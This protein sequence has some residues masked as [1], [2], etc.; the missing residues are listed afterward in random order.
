MLFAVL[1]A[2]YKPHTDWNAKSP[3]FHQP[4]FDTRIFIRR[5][6][7]SF[8]IDFVT[9]QWCD[10][11]MSHS[12]NHFHF[13]HQSFSIGVASMMRWW[14][15]WKCVH[16]KKPFRS[17]CINKSISFRCDLL[18]FKLDIRKMEAWKGNDFFHWPMRNRS[19]N[20]SSRV[21]CNRIQTGHIYNFPF[22]NRNEFVRFSTAVFFQWHHFLGCKSTS[23]DEQIWL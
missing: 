11:F 4:W 17:Q 9:C 10:S 18:R 19:L 16:T 6:S 8:R 2:N 14:A 1:P 15:K 5:I 13:L 3:N 7:L 21:S 12:S 23:C 22:K 20:W